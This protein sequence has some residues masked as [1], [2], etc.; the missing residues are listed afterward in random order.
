M[1]VAIDLL[2]SDLSRLTMDA[3]VGKRG[4]AALMTADGRLV[5]MPRHALIRNEDDIRQRSLKTPAEAGLTTLAHALDDWMAD[6]RPAGRAEQFSSDGET[7]IARFQPLRVRNLQL[8]V[9]TLAPRAEFALGTLWDAAAIGAM[10][11]LVLAL[12]FIAGRRFSLRFATVMD[13]LITESERIGAMQ[14]DKP[15]RVRTQLREIAKLVDAQEHMRLMLLEATRELEAKVD[16]RTRELAEREN[17]VRVL[18]DSSVLGLILRSRDGEIRH[19]SPRAAQISGYTV[20]EWRALPI[21][22]LYADPRDRDRLVEELDRHGQARDF[23]ARF[24]RKDG[25]EFWGVQN[26]TYVE[27]RGES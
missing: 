20:E 27:I 9:A 1:F 24:R 14:L 11:L 12:A 19:V 8:L 4:A 26:S 5:G 18:M 23:E 10:M 15:V 2:L 6:G 7:W 13:S 25:T 21:A 17:F 16:A 22:K 3:K